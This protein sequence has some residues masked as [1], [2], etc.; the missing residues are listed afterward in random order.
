V[1]TLSSG[2]HA[3]SAHVEVDDGMVS[4]FGRLLAECERMLK[5]RF[6]ISHTTIQVECGA[7]EM[8]GC[9]LGRHG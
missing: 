5:E 9:P 7:C 3:M 8:D 4:G 6:S 2:L 1:W